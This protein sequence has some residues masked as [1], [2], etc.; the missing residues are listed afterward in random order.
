MRLILSF[1]CLVLLTSCVS[2]TRTEVSKKPRPVREEIPSTVWHIVLY[3][4]TGEPLESWTVDNVQLVKDTGAITF[5]D[6][7]GESIMLKRNFTFMLVKDGEWTHADFTIMTPQELL[8]LLEELERRE[9]KFQD[10][11]TEI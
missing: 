2:T 5:K 1:L 8:W 3:D 7:N 9:K 4:R 6:E 10:S 11:N